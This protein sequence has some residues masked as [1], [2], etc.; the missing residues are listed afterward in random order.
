MLT[1]SPKISSP[2]DQHVA[3]IDADAKTMRFSGGTPALRSTI[4]LL[5]PIAHS[6]A[7]TTER[8]SR[9]WPS[10]VRLDDTSP[11]AGHDRPRRL[12]VLAHGLCR[13]RL[14]FAHQAG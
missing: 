14:V 13:P 9:G 6:T 8:N 2:L 10:P 5:N 1:P 7:A 11:S 12:A 4:S 3:E